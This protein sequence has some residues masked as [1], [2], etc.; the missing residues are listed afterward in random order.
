MKQHILSGYKTIKQTLIELQKNW[1]ISLVNYFVML[2]FVLSL[3]FILF[4]FKK[5]PPLIPLFFSKPWGTERLAP[6]YTLFLLPLS[7]M[8]W[9]MVNIFLSTYEVKKYITFTQILLLSSFLVNFLS[10][11]IVLRITTMI[12]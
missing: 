8:F 10:F 5:Y 1:L 12:L 2:L 4:N 6:P 9:H 3:A 11:I 7:G